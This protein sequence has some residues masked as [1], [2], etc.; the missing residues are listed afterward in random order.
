MLKPEPENDP[1]DQLFLLSDAFLKKEDIQV[2]EHLNTF[3][4]NLGC[5]TF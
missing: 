1:V 3:T 2:I 5:P 4:V